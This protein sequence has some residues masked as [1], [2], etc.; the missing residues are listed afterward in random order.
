MN[1]QVVMKP[2]EGR[3]TTNQ[4]LVFLSSLRL[5][6]LKERLE[7][8]LAILEDDRAI[9]LVG[10]SSRGGIPSDFNSI[11]PFPSYWRASHA[12]REE[13]IPSRSR[14]FFERNIE[15]RRNSSDE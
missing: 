6:F 11:I 5:P 15:T 2:E 1:A 14:R 10:G 8:Y 3:R 12:G 4:W 9:F 13:I 7:T